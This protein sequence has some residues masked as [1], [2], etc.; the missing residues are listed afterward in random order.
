MFL[1]LPFAIWLSLVLAGLA[2]SDCGLSFLQAWVS[3]PG[4][5]ALSGG[6]LGM[7]SCGTGS[8]P[9]HRWKLE[10]SC[11]LL[12]LGPCVLMALGRSLLGQEFEQKWWYHL[13]SQVCQH[14]WETS[15]LS[16]GFRYREL[17]DRDG[18]RAQM[19]TRSERLH[20]YVGLAL[21]RTEKASLCNIRPS[22]CLQV[23]QNYWY[24]LAHISNVAIFL[25]T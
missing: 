13:C 21:T 25:T 3:T 22:S 10:G 11:P 12:F 14:F 18:S 15:S 1:C 2:V 16:E 4:R 20:F 23:G 9:G 6:N 5:P 8:A 7:E 24:P 17:W 19:E